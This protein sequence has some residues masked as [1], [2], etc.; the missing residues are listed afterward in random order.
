MRFWLSEEGYF[1][2]LID[3]L[4]LAAYQRFI[5]PRHQHACH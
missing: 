1:C 2:L 5:A 4:N 3:L